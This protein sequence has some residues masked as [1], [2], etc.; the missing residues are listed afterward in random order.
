MIMKESE[1]TEMISAFKCTASLPLLA[2]GFG[3]EYI[4]CSVKNLILPS[5][6]ENL[7]ITQTRERRF[8]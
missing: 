8:Y 3:L 5:F 6:L 7:A 1:F 2:V 4:G